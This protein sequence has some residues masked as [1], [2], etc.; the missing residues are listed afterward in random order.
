MLWGCIIAF[1]AER[2]CCVAQRAPT[3]SNMTNTADW[4]GMTDLLGR[5]NSR[6]GFQARSSLAGRKQQAEPPRKAADSISER[7]TVGRSM[8]ERR[9]EWLRL[10]RKR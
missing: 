7:G 3:S 1:R 5:E 8:V 6:A 4:F 2:S 9:E 10:F